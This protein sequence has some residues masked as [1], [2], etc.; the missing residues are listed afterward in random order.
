[1]KSE[2]SSVAA[3]IDSLPETQREETR[4]IRECIVTNLPDGFE[5][6]M[7]Y[8]MITYS[9][10]LST[11]PKG[12]HA[13]P[14]KPLP[15]LS[16][17]AQKNYVALYHLGLYADKDTL[18]WF[19]KAYAAQTGKKPDMGKSCIRLKKNAAIPFDV[20]TAL[21]SKITVPD[22]IRIYESSHA[23]KR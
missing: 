16:L 12:Y 2:V 5:E 18:A 13:N 20:I 21:V 9:V 14:G 8:G 4:M 11:Y 7:A 19:T 23:G 10:P 1:M 15:F 22:Y 17:A 6:G 3:Y